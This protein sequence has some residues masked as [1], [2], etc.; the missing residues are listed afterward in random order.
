MQAF[1]VISMI[2]VFF[3]VLSVALFVLLTPTR[4]VATGWPDTP[5]GRTQVL[6]LL[7]TLNADLLSHDSATLTLERWCAVHKMAATTKVRAT[8]IR[9]TAKALPDDLR[10]ALVAA[11]DEPIAYRRVTLACGSHI[12]SEADN[13]YLP[14]RL[15]PAM[16]TA[17]DRTDTPFGK[18]VQSLHF[19]RT[20]LSAKLLWSPLPEGW[21]LRSRAPAHSGALAIPHQLLQHKA[22]LTAADG[23]PF[24]AVVETYTE[25]VLARPRTTH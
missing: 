2:R 6:A 24:S 8:R 10:A 11:P 4:A 13:W 18:V 20:T 25:Q 21:E 15:T 23:R 9:R 7:E 14:R 5:L 1:D 3:L 16:N 17:L 22:V 19:R 12:L